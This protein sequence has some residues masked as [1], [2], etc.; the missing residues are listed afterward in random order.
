MITVIK[1]P[2]AHRS[3]WE[4]QKC[5]VLFGR[6]RPTESRLHLH[7]ALG[8]NIWVI[9]QQSASLRTKMQ[10]HII[11]QPEAYCLYTTLLYSIAQKIGLRNMTSKSY[12]D[13]CGTFS[14]QLI[15][16][17]IKYT[18]FLTVRKNLMNY[19]QA[20]Y[21]HSTT[22]R[23]TNNSMLV[24]YP[25]FLPNFVISN[26]DLVS[27]LQLPNGLRRGEVRVMRN[28]THQT[29]L[30]NTRPLNPEAP[31]S[32]RKHCSTDDQKSACRRSARHQESLEGDEPSKAPPAKPSPNLTWMTLGPMGLP[33]YG[34]L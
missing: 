7:F 6:R 21:K 2:H 22:I 25:L 10:S 13:F 31:M 34:R 19:T 12:L 5:T 18:A 1:I 33:G 24:F 27:S 3:S 14:L 23:P 28:M 8:S 9:I 20:K 29:A 17:T 4:L 16:C 26:Y 11:T 15:C 30:L 32:Q